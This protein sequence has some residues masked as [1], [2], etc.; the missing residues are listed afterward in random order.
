M[1]TSALKTSRDELIEALGSHLVFQGD[2]GRLMAHRLSSIEKQISAATSARVSQS[3]LTLEQG[4]RLR[5]TERL[6]DKADSDH[7]MIVERQ[8]L[9]EMIERTLFHDK[10]S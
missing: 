5:L 3:R 4:A 2:S 6:R 7:R 8:S 9:G 1:K 10:S